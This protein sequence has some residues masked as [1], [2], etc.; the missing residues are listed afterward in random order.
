[1]QTIN[2]QL[3]N[4]YEILE[5]TQTLK[6]R[7]ALDL[8]LSGKQSEFSKAINNYNG[9]ITLFYSVSKCPYCGNELPVKNVN[10]ETLSR[11]VIAQWSS[12]QL[13]LFEQENPDLIISNRF[14][15]DKIICCPCCKKESKKSDK[16]YDVAISKKRGKIKVSCLFSNIEEMLDMGWAETLELKAPFV[17]YETIVFNLYNGHTYIQIENQD[18]NAICTRDT[19]CSF[20]SSK[21]MWCQN[22]P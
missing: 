10:K 22:S 4:G 15:V 8:L 12:G 17:Y 5:K 20:L 9:T 3:P 1:M 2:L 18:R 16:Y 7:K 14:F 13:T 21:G 6:T 11:D 19:K